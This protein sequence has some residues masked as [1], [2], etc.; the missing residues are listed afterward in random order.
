MTI[1]N[2]QEEYVHLLKKIKEAEEKAQ[3]E[4]ENHKK[5]I[6]GEIKKLQTDMEKAIATSKIEGEKLV[7]SSIE[8]ARKKATVETEK[9]I[10]DAK[11]KA[12][13]ISTQVNAQTTHEIIDILLKGVID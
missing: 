6:E 13:T 10:E 4:I 3:A 9:I 5:I 7:E 1:S 8:Q 12:K 2:T 11:I